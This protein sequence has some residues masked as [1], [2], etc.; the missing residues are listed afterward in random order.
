MVDLIMDAKPPAA[1]APAPRR[2]KKRQILP[3]V[4]L[5]LVA[6][7][8]AWASVRGSWA[9]TVAKDPR[10]PADGTVCQ[11]Y[12]SPDGHKQ[13]RCALLVDAP[14]E[15]VWAVV[16]DYEHFDEIFPYLQSTHAV[17]EAD[18]RYHLTGT[19]AAPVYGSW[20]FDTHLTHRE[21]PPVY[22]VSWD[23][24]GAELTCNRGSWTLTPT[25]PNQTLI[26]YLLE[27]EVR[28]FPRFA[29]RNVLLDRVPAVVSA[30][31]KRL[32]TQAGRKT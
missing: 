29:V 17:R 27:L 25:G 31:A 6:G 21:G 1:P 2:L 23:E 32:Q 8:L 24:P 22:V 12:Q 10:S 4:L 28:H 20:T 9:D 11:L 14:V 5:A 15:Q 3:L 26:V 16:T 19:A 13:V 18:G 30:V 7:F